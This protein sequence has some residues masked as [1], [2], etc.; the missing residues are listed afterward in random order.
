M[1]STCGQGWRYLCLSIEISDTVIA[2]VW[3][4][5]CNCIIVYWWVGWCGC[6]NRWVCGMWI[7][8]F[9]KRGIRWCS[10]SDGKDVERYW[11]WT[12]LLCKHVV[13]RNLVQRTEQYIA[14]DAICCSVCSVLL[15]VVFSIVSVWFTKYWSLVQIQYCSKARVQTCL[16]CFFLPLFKSASK[17]L[18]K[19]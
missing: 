17:D 13:I 14:R 7:N 4:A 15:R 6:E 10:A 3:F 11:K 8:C 16:L 2:I 9:Q 5:Y 1:W 19:N 18:C 12:S